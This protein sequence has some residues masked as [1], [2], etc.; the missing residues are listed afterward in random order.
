MREFCGID[1][2]G[3]A[4]RWSHPTKLKGERQGVSPL[5]ILKLPSRQHQ[6]VDY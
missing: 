6:P 3:L 2:V 4:L 1:D 5:M